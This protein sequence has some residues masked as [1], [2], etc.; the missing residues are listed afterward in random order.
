MK[1]IEYATLQ[2]LDRIELLKVLNKEKV[3]EHLVS[4]DEFDEAL[5]KRWVSDKVNVDSSNRV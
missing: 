5:L 3:R 1:N 2:D 4:H